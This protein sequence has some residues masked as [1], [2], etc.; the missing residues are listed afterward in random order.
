MKENFR[1]NKHRKRTELLKNLYQC[2]HADSTIIKWLKCLLSSKNRE[3]MK[4]Q[5]GTLK[6][7]H[8]TALRRQPRVLWGEVGPEGRESRGACSQECRVVT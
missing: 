4:S 1:Q 5:V 2:I 3:S 6:E 8:C 7:L